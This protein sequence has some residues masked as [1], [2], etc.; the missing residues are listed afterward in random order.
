MGAAEVDL[1][2]G[3]MEEEVSPGFNSEADVL[4][5]GRQP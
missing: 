5:H 2:P 3:W 1:K 4:E